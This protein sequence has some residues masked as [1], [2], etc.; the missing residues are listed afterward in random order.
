IEKAFENADV[1]IAASAPGPNTLKK[2]WISKMNKDAIVFALANPVPE[3]W[4]Y[5][6]K[7]AG[8]KIVATGR[9]DFPNQINNSLVFPAVFRGV[10]DVRAKTI[11][12]EM[13]I[14]AAY[15]IA[16]FAEEKGLREDYIVPTMEEWEVYPRVAAAVAVKAVEQGFARKT[17]TYKEELQNATEIILL[18]RKKLETI[19]EKNLIKD[20]LSK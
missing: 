13:A 3:I 10:L 8:A 14:A 9:S 16:R 11:S 2:E 4:P 6:A 18:S 17:T 7:K 5:E 1:L 12:D 20:P 19:L 15:E